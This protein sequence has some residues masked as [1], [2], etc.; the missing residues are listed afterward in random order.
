MKRSA[1]YLLL[2][3]ICLVGLRL[4]AKRSEPGVRW[5]DQTAANGAVMLPNGWRITPAGEHI[6]LPGD[7]PMKMYVM[8]G[9]SKL[10][11][12]TGGFH[13]HSLNVIDI[14]SRK[15]EAT[16]D[17]I[18]TWDGMAFDPASGTAYI[19]GG[20]KL[21][22]G[23]G[24]LLRLMGILSPMRAS[25][26]TPVL[27]VRYADGKLNAQSGLPISGLDENR[28]FISG[29]TLGRNGSLYALNI[30]T[31][32]LYKMSG[33]GY[34][35]QSSAKTGYRP[36]AAAFSP[37]GGTL[38]VSNW[39]DQSISFFNPD[40]L[41]ET[42][43]VKVGSHPNEL[44]WAGDGRLFVANSGSN[45]V[46]VIRGGAVAETIRTSMDPKA[47]VGS[48]P[49][50]LALS[51]DGKRL[52]VANADN[53]NVAVI[54]TSEAESKVLGFIPTGW[55]P[56]ALAI[57]PDGRE[58]YVGTGKGMGFRN[59][60]PPQ[61]A[62]FRQT[63]PNPAQP[64]DYIAALL[65][66]HVSV[67]GVPDAKQLAAYTR[68][69]MANVP[70]PAANVDSALAAR[71]RRN[72]F[73]QIKH[74]VYIIR[75]NRTYDQVLGDLGR[76]N[77]D[78]K[79]V[80]FGEK[81]TPNAHT[82]AK[83]FVTL[84]N[85]Y[86]D[87]EVS[88]DGHQW[89]DA[90]YAT[91][92]TQKA[93]VNSYSKRGEPDADERLVAS[94][95]GYLWDNCE[96]HGLSY[97]TYGE[98]ASFVSSPESEPEVKASSSLRDHASLEWLKLKAHG[99]RDT[100]KA[101]IFIKELHDAEAAG[102]WPNFMVM[103]LGED[104]T[105]GLRPGAFTPTAA[106]ANNDQAVG[107][108]V[109]AVS[110]SR[111][112]KETAIFILEDDA[113]NGPDHVDAHRTVGLVVSPWVKRDTVDSIFYTSSS[114]VHTIELILG[115]PTMTQFDAAAT[116]MYYSFTAD[117]ALEPIPAIG[118]QVDLMTRNPAEGAGARA[119][120]D[121]DFSDYDRADPDKLNAILWAALKPG[122]PM[123]APVRSARLG[124]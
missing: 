36:Y 93:W 105:Q 91:D 92:F 119:S 103:A 87:G 80:M 74:V 23:G 83:H 54:D 118:P 2:I 59:N 106:V 84:D 96:K 60:Y 77:S 39:G 67:I 29:V 94:P 122:E 100:E 65:S 99:A 38:A 57:S 14:K 89:D 73:P 6:L 15:L 24:Q 26:D 107:Q 81:T 90:A 66:G 40:T 113:Q 58:L 82:L 10:L 85:F 21:P 11:V 68:Q 12:N 30:Q 52:Y 78:P 16:I 22:N 45:T 76:G 61:T 8:A 88:Q 102:N 18:K 37:D 1:F 13:D 72:V 51:P 117:P 44:L 50:A 25:L 98:A 108:I 111:F 4:V 46:S 124:R 27:R 33:A 69:A 114:M 48:T 70:S 17:L 19:S 20:G 116:P 42:G 7:L 53:N 47:P 3:A 123:P 43:R 35:R 115:L 86:A 79:L 75:E 121:L 5:P 9:G 112:W 41:A 62:L 56:T 31:D 49:D 55:Y 63:A 120:L 97:R 104:H 32:A 71:I 109:E 64:Y 95:A 28:R 110:R 34:S 101:A